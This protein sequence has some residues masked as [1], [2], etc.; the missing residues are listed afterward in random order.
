M[1]DRGREA[2]RKGERGSGGD[3]EIIVRPGPEDAK[4]ALFAGL[5]ARREE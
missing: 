1:S 2:R 5:V 3:D 4:E